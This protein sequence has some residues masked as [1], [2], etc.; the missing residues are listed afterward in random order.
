MIEFLVFRALCP[1]GWKKVWH[2]CVRVS[3]N[4]KLVG[5]ISA[6]P[7]RIKIYTKLVHSF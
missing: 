2:C 6:I 3:T 4:K 5:F 1:P 7:A